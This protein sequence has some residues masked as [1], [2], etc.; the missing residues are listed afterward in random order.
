MIVGPQP[1]PIGLIERICH[2]RFVGYL[3]FHCVLD[4]LLSGKRAFDGSNAAG[5]IATG[6]ELPARPIADIAPETPIGC[7]RSA[8]KP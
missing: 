1:S 6:M 5:V 8:A 7:C 2:A 3:A 4:E